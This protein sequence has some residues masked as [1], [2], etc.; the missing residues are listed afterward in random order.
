MGFTTCVVRC[1]FVVFNS[2]I[3]FG[4]V[5]M[6]PMVC[7]FTMSLDTFFRHSLYLTVGQ[8]KEASSNSRPYNSIVLPRL[9]FSQAKT[10]FF[11]EFS[12]VFVL[13]VAQWLK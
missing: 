7:R 12:L 5:M 11:T 8:E 2:G 4:G 6:S 13:S 10:G 1:L 9:M 3:V